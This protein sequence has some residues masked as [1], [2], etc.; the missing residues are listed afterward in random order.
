MSTSPRNRPCPCGSGRKYKK[1]CLQPEHAAHPAPNHPDY[2]RLKGE[3]AERFLRVLA[4]KTFFQDWCF[5]SPKL[6]DKKE[7]CD[8]LVVYDDVA[9]IWQVKDLKLDDA[10]FYK[11]SSV[12]KNLR[13]L[14]GA[15]RQLVDLGTRIEV[16]N[17]HGTRQVLDTASIRE[18]FLVSAMMGEPE[19]CGAFLEE[20]KEYRIHVVGRSFAEL[21]LNELDTVADFIAYLRAKETICDSGKSMVIEGGEEDLLAAYLQDGRTFD[22]F[23][24]ADMVLLSGNMWQHLTKKPEWAAKKEADRVSYA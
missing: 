15:R 17:A 11:R 3:T 8:L 1:C 6:P 5:G 7:L 9:I 18:V 22:Q 19:E 4:K 2:F 20:F 16:T 21:L 10:G 12:E 13:Q 24:K 23:A 14:V